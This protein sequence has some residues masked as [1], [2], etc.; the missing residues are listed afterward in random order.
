MFTLVANDRHG[1]SAKSPISV[2]QLKASDMS[3]TR[4]CLFR[5]CFGF[6]RKYHGCNSNRNGIVLPVPGLE[7]DFSSQ[8]DV[9][10]TKN[11]HVVA[12][13]ALSSRSF[14]SGVSASRDYS[15]DCLSD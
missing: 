6:V 4:W 3:N 10:A 12:V 15:R 7:S 8:P 9:A 11:I 13:Q 1:R 5:R 2:N 14:V